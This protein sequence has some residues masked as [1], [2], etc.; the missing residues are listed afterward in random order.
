MDTLQKE[1]ELPCAFNNWGVLYKESLSQFVRCCPRR[2]ACA[3][4]FAGTAAYAF[5]AIWS[6]KT[7]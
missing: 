1:E 7:L 2:Q 3:G 6:G 4:R 5:L